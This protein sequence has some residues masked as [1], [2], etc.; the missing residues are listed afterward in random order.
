MHR[1]FP[2]VGLR[3]E[4]A[5]ALGEAVRQ[6]GRVTVQPRSIPPVRLLEIGSDLSVMAREDGGPAWPAIATRWRT[7]FDLERLSLLPGGNLLAVGTWEPVAGLAVRTALHATTLSNM[8][9]R[10]PGP[11]PHSAYLS[12]LA[13]AAS[14][15]ATDQPQLLPSTGPTATVTDQCRITVRGRV[16]DTYTISNDRS[17]E[18]VRILWLSAPGS[19]AIQAAVAPDAVAGE[20]EPGDWAE[21]AGLLQGDL[22]AAHRM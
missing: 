19:W 7:E 13:E 10:G 22:V 4:E 17:G 21:V 3:S 1:Y 14:R 16:T 15:R 9:P 20:I 8:D 6:G 2:A 12:V 18:S 5:D 11:G